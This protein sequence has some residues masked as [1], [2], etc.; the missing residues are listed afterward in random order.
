MVN[1]IF[2]FMPCKTISEVIIQLEK[3]VQESVVKED[4]NGYFA[5]LYKKVTIAVGDKIK[6]GYFDDNIRMEKLDVV[7]AN[8]YLE[9]Y[10]QY[11]LAKPCTQSWQL[12]FDA[13]KQW[14]PMVIHHLTAGMNAHIGLDLGIAAATVA[15]GNSIHSIK[16]DF[17]KINIILNG[18]ME[19]VKQDLFDMWP[20]SK[21]LAH[22]RLG[23]LENEIGAFSMSVAR[24]AAWLVALAY[25]P[26]EKEEEKRNFVKSRDNKVALFGRKILYPGTLMQGILYGLRVFETGSIGYKIKKLND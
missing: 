6:E 3:I 5:A 4:R 14:K 7:F 12:A 16:A 2:L 24:D 1:T 21:R 17:D 15:P 23:K 8:R 26:L 25:A 22:F 19:E 18:L 20:M 10:Q 13:A 11:R 9:A